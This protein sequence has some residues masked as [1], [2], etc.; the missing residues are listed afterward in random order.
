MEFGGDGGASVPPTGVTAIEG[1]GKGLEIRNDESVQRLR[2][3]VDHAGPDERWAAVL[4]W[5][6]RR[7]RHEWE[8]RLRAAGLRLREIDG[9]DQRPASRAI[10][11]LTYPAWLAIRISGR[12]TVTYEVTLPTDERH[13][14]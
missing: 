6:T 14:R 7:D 9:R 1:W 10:E 8:E 5:M 4:P 11:V 12:R 2:H 13:R 3:L